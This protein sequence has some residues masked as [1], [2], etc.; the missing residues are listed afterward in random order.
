M[1]HNFDRLIAV[2]T[3]FPGRENPEGVRAQDIAKHL[4]VE[5][6][7][8][9][10]SDQF[11]EE[12]FPEIVW[13]SER[14]PTYDNAF[15][16]LCMFQAIAGEVDAVLIGEGADGMFSKERALS[17]LRYDKKQKILKAVPWAIRRGISALLKPIDVDPLRRLTYL[18]ENGTLEFLRRE[19]MEPLVSDQQMLSGELVPALVDTRKHRRRFYLPFEPANDSLISFC[20]NRGLYT[21]NRNQYYSYIVHADTLGIDIEAPFLS[22]YISDI[23]LSLQDSLKSD[24]RGAK[25]IL[26]KLA[27]RYIPEHWVYASKLGFETPAVAWLKGPLAKWRA[28]LMEERT[29]TRGLF[30]PGALRRLDDERDFLLIWTAMTVEMFCRQFIDIKN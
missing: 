29:M 13:Q 16:R 5:H 7:V 27:C 26:K 4:G 23:G 17:A 15:A 28:I 9:D 20:Q 22:P 24:E 6:R 25:P 1:E 18:L 14:P 19:G 3:W 11:L 12:S 8:V 30:D 21:Q 2:T 10:V